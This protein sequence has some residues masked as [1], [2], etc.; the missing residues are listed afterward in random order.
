MVHLTTS[1]ARSRW[2]GLVRPMK[3]KWQVRVSS[4]NESGNP[5]VQEMLKVMS[6]WKSNGFD[7]NYCRQELESFLFCVQRIRSGEKDTGKKDTG[8]LAEN[9]QA[10]S[11]QEVNSKF[12][13]FIRNK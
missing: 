8:K 5:C 13:E 1:L 3:L 7:D 12:R 2:K 10:W 4:R 9:S 11:P 6:C